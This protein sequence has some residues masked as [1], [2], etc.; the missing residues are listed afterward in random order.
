MGERIQQRGLI[1]IGN[2]AYVADADG[3]SPENGVHEFFPVLFNSQP[4]DQIVARTCLYET[5]FCVF[6]IL[7]AVNDGVHRT[8]SAKN[9][10]AAFFAPGSELPADLFN[11]V[12]GG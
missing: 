7:N 4:F 1:V 5:D 10:K 9:D 11:G 12:V 6:K 2:P 8:V 3:L